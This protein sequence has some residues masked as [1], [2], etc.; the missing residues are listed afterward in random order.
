MAAT[1][2]WHLLGDEALR[3]WRPTVTMDATEG[4]D[5][6]KQLPAS[7]LPLLLLCILSILPVL[8]FLLFWP[9]LKF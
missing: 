9:S 1:P 6:Q 8:S 5:F 7:F 2:V 4:L 3:L